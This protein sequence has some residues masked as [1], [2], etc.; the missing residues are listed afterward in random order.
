MP[1][2]VTHSYFAMDVLN[3]LDTKTKIFLENHTNEYKV[4]AQSMDPFNFYDILKFYKK[5]SHDIREFTVT[6][7]NNETGKFLVT[8]TKNIKKYNY[9]NNPSVIAFLYGLIAHYI[10]DS[11]AHPF[12]I[13]KTGKVEKDQKETWKYNAKHH[14]MEAYIDQ[15]M[16][17]EREHIKAYNYKHYKECLCIKKL[18]KSLIRLVNEIYED[19]YSFNDFH[20]YY[21]NSIKDMKFIFKYLRYDPLSLMKGLYYIFD[22]I[23]PKNVLHSKFLSYHYKPKNAEKFLNKEHLTWY[24]PADKSI[25]SN[26]SFEDIYNDA[27]KECIGIINSVNDYLYKDKEVNLEKLYENKSYETGIDCSLKK[28]AK[29]FEY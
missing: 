24:N 12:I 25:F 26:S 14:E 11:Y 15:V 4:Y 7:H 19:I 6:F 29:Y 22:F 2:T 1:S 3:K 10:L 18:D 21:W 8:L 9:Q 5:K 13:Y 27:K 20:K 17:E 28:E 16:I 23:M